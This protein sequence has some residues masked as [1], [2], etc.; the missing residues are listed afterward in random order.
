[1]RRGGRVSAFHPI[2]QPKPGSVESNLSTIKRCL[3]MAEGKRKKLPK[4]HK[5]LRGLT[6]LQLEEGLYECW[7]GGVLPKGTFLKLVATD[8]ALDGIKA[9]IEVTSPKLGKGRV[10]SWMMENGHMVFRIK[11]GRKSTPDGKYSTYDVLEQADPGQGVSLEDTRERIV[12]NLCIALVVICVHTRAFI[13]GDTKKNIDVENVT[14]KGAS[15]ERAER[16]RPFAWE[17]IRYLMAATTVSPQSLALLGGDATL[18]EALRNT[19]I[20]DMLCFRDAAAGRDDC[21]VGLMKKLYKG[22]APGQMKQVDDA[23]K[24]AQAA[25]CQRRVLT[26]ESMVFPMAEKEL[27]KGT[28]IPDTQEDRAVV[29]VPVGEVESYGVATRAILARARTGKDFCAWMVHFPLYM[30]LMLSR[31]GGAIKETSENNQVAK[32]RKKLAFVTAAKANCAKDAAAQKDRWLFEEVHRVYVEQVAPK[33]KKAQRRIEN[34]LKRVGYGAKVSGGRL[35]PPGSPFWREQVGFLKEMVEHNAFKRIMDLVGDDA[36][37]MCK[38]VLRTQDL[39]NILERNDEFHLKPKGKEKE[40]NDI[41]KR[42]KPNVT[43][44]NIATFSHGLALMD[45]ILNACLRPQDLLGILAFEV[46][47]MTIQ[48]AKGRTVEVLEAVLPLIAKNTAASDNTDE[49]MSK[50]VD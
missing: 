41:V 13:K 31:P 11:W 23:V 46:Y 34:A 14:L 28:K 43:A 25:I 1:M 38:E 49:G 17:R 12:T 27:P 44:E 39:D 26:L 37:E 47:L 7:S 48:T 45:A 24:S 10:A 19:K 40:I 4:R 30:L 8:P 20:V 9:G 18:A 22:F 50:T 42:L 2:V 29:R 6:L 35:H 16:V 36:V 21:R 15:L 32:T 3:D 33:K 5:D